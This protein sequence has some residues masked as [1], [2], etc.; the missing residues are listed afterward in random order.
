VK[1]GRIMLAVL[2]TTLL[3]AGLVGSASAGRLQTSSQRVKATWARLEFRGGF[4]T[5]ECEVVVEGSFHARTIAK[6]TGALTG[7][8]TVATITRCAR[9]TA[10]VLRETLPWH[11]QYQSFT[12]TLPNITS[13][14][15]RVV[16][17]AFVMREPTFGVTCL[18]R[19]PGTISFGQAAGGVIVQAT[20]GGTTP[21]GSFSGT[22]GGSTTN[23]DNGSGA[24]VTVTLI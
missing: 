22:L 1:L 24:R 19:G 17:I 5:V 6:T 15:A 20:A 7:S 23:V 10:T 21:C 8:I 2:G 4:G 3:S 9:G 14:S 18:A 12:G 11:V 16:E 13:I